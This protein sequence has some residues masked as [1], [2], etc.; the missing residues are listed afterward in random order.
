MIKKY[1]EISWTVFDVQTLAPSL[2]DEQAK[3]WL[4]NNQNHIQDRLIEK[5]WD[6]IEDLLSSDGISL[7]GEI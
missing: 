3:D 5:G 2:T 7:E 6:V 4:A 1:A